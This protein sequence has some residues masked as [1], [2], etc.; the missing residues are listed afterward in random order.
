MAESTRG[1][2]AALS[3]KLR[4]GA[5]IGFLVVTLAA[6][7]WSSL[8]PDAVSAEAYCPFGGIETLWSA[9]TSGTYVYNLSASNVVALLLVLGSAALLGRAFCGWLCPVGSIQDGAAALARRLL[10]RDLGLPWQ[11]PRRLDR[12]L[13]WLKMGVLLW[14][15]WT[16][17]SAFVPALAPFCPLRPLL[18][19]Q[20]HALLTVGVLMLLGTTSM[21]VERFFCRYLCPLGA[22]LA[23]F[24][25]ISPLRPR[26]HT[27]RCV[28]CGRCARACP[29]GLDPTRDGTDHPECVRCLACTAACRREGAMTWRRETAAP[30][31]APE[32]AK[33]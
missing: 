11:V 3:P 8:A 7:L 24:N 4:R 6:G 30:H 19:I 31:K 20:V 23:L 5:Q 10:G 25:M 13:R 14:V 16:S 32:P 18:N 21:L 33:T 22:L 1:R 27:L 2:L 17:L 12:P 28:G 15:L 26:V 29:M 9:V